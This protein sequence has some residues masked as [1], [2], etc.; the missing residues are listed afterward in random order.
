MAAT[1]GAS[2]RRD[3]GR[4][5]EALVNWDQIKGQWKQM[6]GDVRKQWAKLTDDD[7]QEA[8]GDRE[9]FEGKVQERYGLTKEEARRRVDQWLSDM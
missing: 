2:C 9:K 1:A 6:Q 5:G 8:R 7:I 4:R 3:S